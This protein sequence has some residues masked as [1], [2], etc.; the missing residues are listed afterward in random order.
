MLEDQLCRKELALARQYPML[1]A[2]MVLPVCD[3]L[4]TIG[5]PEASTC[6]S[7]GISQVSNLL[8][9]QHTCFTGSGTEYRG[10][11]ATTQTGYP[12][13]PWNRK[14]G[15]STAQLELVGGHNYCRNPSVFNTDL[16][17]PWCFS[18]QNPDFPEPCGIHKCNNIN[19]YLYVVIPAV[20]AVAITP[21]SLSPIRAGVGRCSAP[22]TTAGEE[23]VAS[24]TA[25]QVSLR[26]AD[27]NGAATK[28][29]NM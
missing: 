11:Y 14:R 1:G 18:A 7:I 21:S 23:P 27:T 19:L 9:P 3:E 15:F 20:A 17:E 13:L 2:Q 6:V 28:T 26:S 10:T 25:H 29:M 12:C 8:K 4:P 5:S 24:A 22:T 16:E